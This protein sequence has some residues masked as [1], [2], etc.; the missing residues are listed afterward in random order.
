MNFS[1]T[2][3]ILLVA[4]RQALRLGVEAQQLDVQ[5]CADIK[6]GENSDIFYDEEGCE[7]DIAAQIECALIDTPR[8]APANSDVS[9]YCLTYRYQYCPGIKECYTGCTSERPLLEE[10][11]S[12]CVATFAM[13]LFPG[14]EDADCSLDC[15]NFDYSDGILMS[16]LTDGD[17]A[18]GDDNT[19]DTF[20]EVCGSIEDKLDD[21][22]VNSV[23][24]DDFSQC[25]TQASQ[26]IQQEQQP[27]GNICRAQQVSYCNIFKCY[28][29]ECRDAI[30]SW[31]EC[32]IKEAIKQY[33]E[34]YEQYKDDCNLSLACD[35]FDLVGQ[36]SDSVSQQSG[37]SG[38]SSSASNA[39]RVCDLSLP[40][41]GVISIGVLANR[42]I[43][44]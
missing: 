39:R 36:G 35:N 26:M 42:G 16:A 29:S 19:D 3:A 23:F 2:V 4:S 18:F 33:P 38:S 34:L 5:A 41:I 9:D 22:C 1:S 8:M 7:I 17:A 12:S 27:S 21:A 30:F 15:A 11:Y 40:G 20:S 10:E 43:S 28:P 31:H 25:L 6:T 24:P 14:N 44:V 13:R 32:L 37:G